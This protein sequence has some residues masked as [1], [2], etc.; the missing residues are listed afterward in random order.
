MLKASEIRRHY[1]YTHNGD[2]IPSLRGSKAITRAKYSV[3]IR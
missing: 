1:V 3:S 2:V